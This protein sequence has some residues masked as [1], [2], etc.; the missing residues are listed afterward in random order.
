MVIANAGVSETT[1]AIEK[2][3]KTSYDV[4]VTTRDLFKIDVVI[5]LLIFS[6]TSVSPLGRRFQ[7]RS[8]S[9]CSNER[10]QMYFIF[11]LT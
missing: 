2:D 6:V 10:P 11:E 7:Y 5:K 3:G 9:C 1:L 4:A 8:S